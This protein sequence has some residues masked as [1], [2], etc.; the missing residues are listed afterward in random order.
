[1]NCKW[2]KLIYP[3]PVVLNLH[4][5]MEWF[6]IV[7]PLSLSA[8]VWKHC[9]HNFN[10][11]LQ[12]REGAN[13]SCLTMGS[14]MAIL[15]EHFLPGTVSHDILSLTEGRAQFKKVHEFMSRS[16]TIFT[17]IGASTVTA[18]FTVGLSHHSVTS[19]NLVPCTKSKRIPWN[20][21][22]KKSFP[23]ASFCINE[24]WLPKIISLN[25]NFSSQLIIFIPSHSCTHPDSGPFKNVFQVLE[26][27]KNGNKISGI[28]LLKL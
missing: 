23:C 28:W 7:P 13:L 12:A 2:W 11:K 18:T 21:T 4:K 6:S 17:T 26:F 3:L 20:P 8:G 24:L 22:I 19:S 15:F 1:M 25:A 9:I 27:N 16:M 10:N 14:E 5:W